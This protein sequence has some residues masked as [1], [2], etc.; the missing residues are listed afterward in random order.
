MKIVS[1]PY[2]K[3]T[4]KTYGELMLKYLWKGYGWGE[5]AQNPLFIK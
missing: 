1:I 5:N 3:F 2:N 4:K